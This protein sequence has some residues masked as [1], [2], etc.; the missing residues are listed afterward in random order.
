MTNFL[1][2]LRISENKMAKIVTFDNRTYYENDS[3][4]EMQRQIDPSKFFR[5]NRQYIISHRAIKDI[6]TWFDSKLSINL[7]VDVPE[8]IIVSRTR[9]TEFKDWYMEKNWQ[10]NNSV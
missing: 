10:K 8:K 2:V 9:V 7:L 6:S 4:D 1:I 5:A 3:L